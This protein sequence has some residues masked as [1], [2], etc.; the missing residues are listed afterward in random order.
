M[1]TGSAR[2]E[3]VNAGIGRF[4]TQE[5]IWLC[6]ISCEPPGRALAAGAPLMV[7]SRTGRHIDHDAVTASTNKKNKKP[8][9][10][11]PP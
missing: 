1:G 4:N 6:H 11:N 8:S 9:P 2:I 3:P 7:K 5:L 10:E